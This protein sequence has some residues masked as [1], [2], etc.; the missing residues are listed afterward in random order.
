MEATVLDPAA[1]LAAIRDNARVL[2][3]A[4]E[5]AGLDA[6]VPTCPD[7]DV[8]ELLAHIGRV[9]RW[10]ASNTTRSPDAGYAAPDVEI[11]PP[12][13]RAAWVRVGAAEL[14]AA[15]ER[16]ADDPA[17][18]WMAPSTIGFWQR[19]QA[20]ETAM[21]RVD[22]ES[23]TGAPQPIDAALAADGIDEW[24]EIVGNTPWRAPP[25]GEGESLHFHCTD[26]EGEWVVRLVPTGVEVERVH[27]K[28]DV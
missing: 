10:A 14:V 26:V 20:H 13:G 7:W 15:L 19:R 16:P 28:G 2:V 21:H 18:T 8:A 3:D 24:F 5:A 6:R 9:H 17:W 11:P 22:A 23:A 27:A 25:T 4:A 12:R 1:Y